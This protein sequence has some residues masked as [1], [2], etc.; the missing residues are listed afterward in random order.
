[1][2]DPSGVL[3]AAASSPGTIMQL[4]NIAALR[5][6]EPPTPGAIASVLEYTAN[7]RM[8]GGVFI[9]D[10][11][12]TRSVDDGGMTFVTEK[13]KRWKR[14]VL[15]YN[16]VT[17]VDFGA[18]ADGE[19]D[20]IEA[21]KRMFAW[22]QRVL[23]SAGIKF[24]AGTFSMST[25][26]ISDKEINRF[27]VSGATVNFGYFPTTTLLFNWDTKPRGLHFFKVNAR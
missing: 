3:A 18:V 12:D 26:D 20:C 2:T 11:T 23:P 10:P 1:M 27:K 19:T 16:S 13:G 24:I 25:F 4:P 22:S 14:V 6:A 17:V 9:Y 15:D 5:Q 8:G 21:V 7:T